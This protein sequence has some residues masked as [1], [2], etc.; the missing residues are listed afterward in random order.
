MRN[1]YKSLRVK[2]EFPICGEANI[3]AIQFENQVIY[4]R[5]TFIWPRNDTVSGHCKHDIISRCS[6]WV[7]NF[8]TKRPTV[9]VSGRELF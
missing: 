4:V 8:M 7:E 3:T 6:N 1:A 2:L 9:S 5:A